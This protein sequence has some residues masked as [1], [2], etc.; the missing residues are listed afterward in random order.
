MSKKW[1]ILDRDGTLILDKNYL[2]N[3]DGVELLPNVSK[4]LL[5][6]GQFGYKFVVVSNQSGVGRGYF[7]K[8]DMDAVN[9]RVSEL[10]FSGGVVIEGFYSCPHLP[11]EKCLCRKPEIGLV[12][13]AAKELNFRLDEVLCVIGDKESDIK[14][15]SNIGVMSLL[16]ATGYGKHEY[17][18]GIR[19][20]Y[21]AQDMLGVSD[22]LISLA[23]DDIVEQN[24]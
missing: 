7:T 10:L 6:L 9:K 1:I 12:E 16:L 19:G 20:T 11:E 13:S 22:L 4:G 3:P 21:F 14:L 8:N 24:N 2:G 15:A 23:K 18:R 5:R 17:E